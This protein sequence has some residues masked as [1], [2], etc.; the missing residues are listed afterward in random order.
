MLYGATPQP[1]TSDM[2]SL[3]KKQ[4]TLSAYAAAHSLTVNSLYA[5]N[6]PGIWGDSSAWAGKSYISGAGGSTATLNVSST[7]YGALTGSGTVTLAGPGIPGCP[8]NCPTF[9]RG[10]GPT[11]TLTWGS[12]IAAN[13]GSSGSPVQMTAGAWKPATPIATNSFKAISIRL[14]AC[15]RCM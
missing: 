14:A 10:S 9:P 3:C 6:D 15:R 11:Y 4:T 12:A 1:S 5:L 2:A 13:V 8:L 7:Q